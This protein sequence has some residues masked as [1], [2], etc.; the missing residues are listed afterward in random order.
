MPR[1]RFF[2]LTRVGIALARPLLI[3]YGAAVRTARRFL[4]RRDFLHYG[5][6]LVLER[7]ESETWS[8]AWAYIREVDDV[9][10]STDRE[11]ARNV[12]REE[13]VK[14]REL[15]EG[16]ELR[17]PRLLRDS[18]LTY[19]LG[20]LE[21]Y[22]D[23]E[24]REKVY[25]VVRELYWSA[26]LDTARRGKVLDRE[27]MLRLVRYKAAAFFKLYFTLGRLR[28]EGYEDKIAELLGIA[29][30]L[31]DD[32]LDALYDIR[33]GYVNLTKEELNA[34]LSEGLAESARGR[35]LAIL[36]LL[37][38]ARQIAAKIRN[39]LA[40]RTVLRLTE[41]FA[42][43]ILEGRFVPGAIYLFKGGRLLLRLL[44]DD[45][46]VA[47]EVGHRI[48]GTLLSVPQLAPTL[49]KVWVRLTS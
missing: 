41:A 48:I 13:W 33:T 7:I 46:I 25:R 42:A 21:K 45:E 15:T 31:L 11:T 32:F 17:E 16:G 44:P 34:F 19:F 20:N 14:V 49:V 39:P 3:P 38:R 4:R 27:E 28:M 23:D 8:L 2:V 30:G 37:M 47:Y 1:G 9:V 29:L 6:Q 35:G 24:E 43:P 18:W 12:L 10:D 36:R 40:R 22:Y 5:S 26:L